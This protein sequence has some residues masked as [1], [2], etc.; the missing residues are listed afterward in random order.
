MR[1]LR[2]K[3]MLLSTALATTSGGLGCCD[4]SSD[5]NAPRC[6]WEKAGLTFPACLAPH[7]SEFMGTVDGMRFDSKD[8]GHVTGTS[9]LGT[10]PYQLSMALADNGSLDIDWDD[11]Y[12]RGQWTNIKGGTMRVPGDWPKVRTVF[13]DSEILMSCDEYAFLYILHINGGDLTGC[14]R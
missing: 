6:V 1:T 10:P 7:T 8:S 3:L 5:F 2:L 9:P 13:S 11:P 12:L 4:T 14:S